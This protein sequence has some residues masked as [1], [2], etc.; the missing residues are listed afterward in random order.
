MF[1][2]NFNFKVGELFCL[3]VGDCDDMYDHSHSVVVKNFNLKEEARHYIDDLDLTKSNPTPVGVVNF[4]REKG[5]IQKAEFNKILESDIDCVFD[6]VLTRPEQ[7][8][9]KYNKGRRKT[10]SLLYRIPPY[11]L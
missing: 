4:L 3:T 10:E 1:E 2:E 5:F 11:S 7:K 8:I 6:E 9:L